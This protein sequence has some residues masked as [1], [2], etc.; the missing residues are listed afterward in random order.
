MLLILTFEVY[1][2]LPQRADTVNDCVLLWSDS[3]IRGSV[4]TV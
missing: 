1:V 3:L 4:V 2:I